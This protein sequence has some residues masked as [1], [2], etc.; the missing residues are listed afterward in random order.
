LFE[1]QWFRDAVSAMQTIE[2]AETII[3]RGVS[4]LED[5]KRTEN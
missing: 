1:E 2:H 5:K 3:E 4:F